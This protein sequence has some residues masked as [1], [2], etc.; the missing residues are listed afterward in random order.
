MKKALI[1]VLIFTVAL[2][3]AVVYGVAE[4]LNWRAR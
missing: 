3:V 4:K 2:A 1:D